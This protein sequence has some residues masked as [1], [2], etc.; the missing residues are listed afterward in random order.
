MNEQVSRGQIFQE[1]RTLAGAISP[2]SFLLCLVATLTATSILNVGQ[3]GVPFFSLALLIP[4]IWAINPSRSFLD[5]R[6]RA[7][8]VSAILAAVCVICLLVLTSFAHIIANT[9]PAQ[10]EL[11]HAPMR[12]LFLVYFCICVCVLRGDI[13]QSCVVWLRRILIV[14]ALYGIYQVPAKI[15]GLPLPLDW[16]RNNPSL[17]QYDFNTAGWV[18]VARATSI[19]AEPSAAAVPVVLLVILN[20]SLPA[21]RFS[22][23][24]GWFAAVG[25][26]ALTFSRTIWVGVAVALVWYALG[27]LHVVKKNLAIVLP[28]I[29]VL[30]VL[31]TFLLPVLAGPADSSDD[32]STQ[33]RVNSMF[34]A[35]RLIEQRPIIGFGWNSYETLLPEVSTVGLYLDPSVETTHIHNMFLAYVQ[36]GGIAG[37]VLAFFPIFLIIIPRHVPV[38]VRCATFFGFLVI[39]ASADILYAALPWFWVALLW[40]MNRPCDEYRGSNINVRTGESDIARALAIKL[41]SASK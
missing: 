30:L 6:F 13:V 24:V 29:S 33:E 32:L 31:G 18:A 22:K 35:L 20:L 14:A 3:S 9:Q 8:E 27:K 2:Q 1:P 25:F 16:L 34:L 15:L 23:L 21:S 26:A 7:E 36:Q 17:G 28:S 4:V 11:T 38:E 37:L 40:K 41:S 19:F 12:I 10:T 39:A 5:W